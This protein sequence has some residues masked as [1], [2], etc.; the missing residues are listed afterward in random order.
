MSKIAGI[1]QTIL[2]RIRTNTYVDKIP[3]ERALAAE[4][5]VDFK[6]ANRAITMLVEQGTLIRKR[7][8]GTFIAPVNQRQDLTIGLAF[9]KFTDPGR[10]PVFN[11]FFAG[12]NRESRALGLRLDVTALADV[13]GTPPMPLAQQIARFHE[14]V[15]APNPDALIYL[16]NVQLDLIE[17]LR[18]DRPTIVVTQTPESFGFD[19]VCRDVGGGIATAVRHLHGLGHRRIALATY[20]HAEDAYDLAAKELGYHQVIAELGITPSVLIS[21]YYQP[22]HI[23]QL[24]ADSRPTAL[25]C[26]ESTLALNLIR[27]AP[28]LGLRI[29]TDVA[30]AAFDD[31][32]VGS[33]THPTLS[34]LVA[35]GDE[36]AHHAV[37]RLIEKLDGKIEGRIHDQL[38]CPFFPRE[39]SGTAIKPDR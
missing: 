26:T 20:R 18:A 1:S 11:R 5:G 29:P 25:V 16:G 12:I 37:K 30:V 34:N 27:H 36:L 8:L 28:A 24:V 21:D 17:Q 10:D 13:A 39:S 22:M 33:I 23:A 15:L 31:G 9:F 6:T 4:F 3:S 2:T 7:G 19:T 32:D 38:P 14:S 35:F